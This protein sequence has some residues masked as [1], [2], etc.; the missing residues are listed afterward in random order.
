MSDQRGALPPSWLL[1]SILVLFAV[2]A[3]VTLW[4]QGRDASRAVVEAQDSI[5][6]LSRV[7]QARLD[8]L[9]ALRASS[10]AAIERSDSVSA[11]SDSV[12]AAAELDIQEATAAVDS[13]AGEIQERVDSATAALVDTLVVRH[14]SALQASRA[15]LEEERARSAALF[16]RALTAEELVQ[17]LEQDRATRDGIISQYEALE[18]ERARQVK[19]LTWQRNVA[20]GL[21]LICAAAC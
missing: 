11:H 7:S 3:F 6:A 5:A 2:V 1:A 16:R 17:E 8:T 19:S 9:E 14:R 12:Q 13:L 21:A 10:R 15:Q 18:R 4:G 20:G